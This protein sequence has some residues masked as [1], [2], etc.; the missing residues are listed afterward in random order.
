MFIYFMVVF[1]YI[2]F[3]QASVIILYDIISLFSLL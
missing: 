3:M 2:I 1:E